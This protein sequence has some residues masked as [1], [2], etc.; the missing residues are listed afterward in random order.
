LQLIVSCGYGTWGPPIRVGNVPEIVDIN[1]RFI[2]P[3][4]EAA[5]IVEPVMQMM[6][7]LQ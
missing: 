3:T 4:G 6:G 2:E 7:R 5:I 1:I